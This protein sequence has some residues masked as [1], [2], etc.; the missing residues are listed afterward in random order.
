MF[1]FLSL[2]VGAFSFAVV[3]AAEPGCI[4][5]AT[6]SRAREAHCGLLDGPA[7]RSNNRLFKRVLRASKKSC[8]IRTVKAAYL[9]YFY[10]TFNF[11]FFFAKQSIHTILL[12]SSELDIQL[13]SLLHTPLWKQRVFYIH[14]SAL[15]DN[16][17][18]RAK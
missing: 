14:G 17:L 8:K 15:R 5:L 2:T 3:R 11:A 7:V 18:E 9:H 1:F 12:S 6:Q 13:R 10:K 16:D 4:L